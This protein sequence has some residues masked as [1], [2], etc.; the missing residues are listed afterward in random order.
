[1]K[2]FI[3]GGC[4]NGKSSI[5]ED[6]SSK[7]A[8][9]GSLYYIATMLPFD[10]EDRARI[11]RHIRQRD[12]KGFVTVEQ[13]T[14]ILEI[15]NKTD[16]AQGTFLLDSVTALMINEMYCSKN[17]MGE[18]TYDMTADKTAP[19]RV[20]SELTELCSRVKNIIFVS[21]YIY[22]EK[23]NYNEFT[24]EYLRALSLADRALAKACDVVCEVTFG[25]PEIYKGELTF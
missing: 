23:D 1:M 6:I 2:I 5:A 24:E 3:T 21:D 15:L 14:N 18:D 13:A 20:A 7:L 9:G 16:A 17:A 4:K 11:K 22:M 19:Q 25:C 12:G 10:D 8:K